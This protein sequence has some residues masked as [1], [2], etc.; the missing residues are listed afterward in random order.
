MWPYGN[1]DSRYAP[2][3]TNS[4]ERDKPLFTL[5][6]CWRSYSGD[7]RGLLKGMVQDNRTTSNVSQMLHDLGWRDLKDC[8]RGLTLALLYKTVTGHVAKAILWSK[9]VV[10]I[11]GF[12]L[13]FY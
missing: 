11:L 6:R 13:S 7:L 9:R 1:K 2:Y 3:C 12:N 4:S 8:R 10:V 5:V